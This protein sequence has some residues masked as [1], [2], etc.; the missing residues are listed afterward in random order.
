MKYDKRI[1]E[2]DPVGLARKGAEIFSKAATKSVEKR[3]RFVVAISGGST[4]RD[5]HRTL[6]EEPFRSNIPWENTNIF[7]VDERCVPE[8]DPAGNYV[9]AR[10]DFIDRVPIPEAQVYPMQCEG[11]PEYGA[12]QYNLWTMRDGHK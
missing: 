2:S 4:P 11:S 1:I 7:W 8:N 9:A 10:A 6:G 5:M 3:G 12:I